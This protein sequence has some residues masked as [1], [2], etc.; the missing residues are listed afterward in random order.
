MNFSWLPL[1]F[2]VCLVLVWLLG[3]YLPEFFMMLSYMD[4][5]AAVR[6]SSNLRPLMNKR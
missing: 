3:T 6:D 4:Q 2:V 1:S 5:K